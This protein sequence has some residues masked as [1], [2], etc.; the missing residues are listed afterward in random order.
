[1]VLLSFNCFVDGKL[2]MGVI[3]I[4]RIPTIH[5]KFTDLIGIFQ[6]GM[7]G[8][9]IPVWRKVRFGKTNARKN[10]GRVS[11]GKKTLSSRKIEEDSA[12]RVPNHDHFSRKTSKTGSTAAPAHPTPDRWPMSKDLFSFSGCQ[13]NRIRQKG[14][15]RS[16]NPYRQ[17]RI[18]HF[19][20]VCKGLCIILTFKNNY[21][22]EK[23]RS[24]W[25]PLGPYRFPPQIPPG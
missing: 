8:T 22:T 21:H 4:W 15:L 18:F 17:I 25:R 1:M 11:V 16:L 10:L 2:G 13:S 9:L 6:R 14:D 5:I 23:P 3:S 20:R 7:P 24:L 12:C 19:G